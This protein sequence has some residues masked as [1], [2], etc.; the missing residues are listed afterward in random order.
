MDR[1]ETQKK[2]YLTESAAE[3]ALIAAW[4]TYDYKGSQG[5]VGFYLCDN[6]GAYHLTSK[7]EM[8]K[9]LADEISSGR[10]QRQ[11]EADRWINKFKKKS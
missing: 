10:I 7:G 11:A 5:P 3:D 6:C 2:M 9:R 4:I 1:C 8:N